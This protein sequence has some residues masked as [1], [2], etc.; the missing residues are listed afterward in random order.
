MFTFR[1]NSLTSARAPDLLNTL[2]GKAR[3]ANDGRPIKQ[4]N[5]CNGKQMFLICFRPNLAYQI[6]VLQQIPSSVTLSELDS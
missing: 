1:I 2:S 3:A 6:K 4:C 5:K